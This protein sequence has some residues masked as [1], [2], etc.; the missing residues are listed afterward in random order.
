MKKSCKNKFTFGTPE[1]NWERVHVDYADP[2]ENIYSL[3]CVDAKSKWAEVRMSKAVPDSFQTINMLGDI[4][5][6]PGYPTQMVSDNVTIFKS[7][8]FQ[9][10]CKHKGIFHKFI[11]VRHHAT[12][13]LAERNVQTLKNKLPATSNKNVPIQKKLRKILL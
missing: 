12:N 4:F 1:C 6:F 11:F 2:V 8:Q 5:P 7:D 3:I 9:M 10:H 13:G